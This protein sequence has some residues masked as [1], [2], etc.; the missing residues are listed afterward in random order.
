VRWSFRLDAL[1]RF[2]RLFYQKKYFLR[3]SFVSFR[4]WT[5]Y[6]CPWIGLGGLYYPGC[7]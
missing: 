7:Q 2:Y 3:H 6:R 1:E 4:T 5:G